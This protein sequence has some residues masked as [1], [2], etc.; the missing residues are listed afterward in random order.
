M[1]NIVITGYICLMSWFEAFVAWLT[2]PANIGESAPLIATVVCTFALIITITA[3]ARFVAK[4]VT[5]SIDDADLSGYS[6]RSQRRYGGSGVQR[7]APSSGPLRTGSIALD[8]D[9]INQ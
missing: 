2:D 8:L 3:S 9:P 7:S 5:R 4:K 6:S 1:A